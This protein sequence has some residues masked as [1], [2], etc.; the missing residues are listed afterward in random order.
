MRYRY[1]ATQDAL[2]AELRQYFAELMTAEVRAALRSESAESGDAARSVVRRMGAD[3]WLGIGWPVEYGGQ[4]PHGGSSSSSSSTRS[5]GPDAPFPFV[6]LNTVGPALMAHGSEE[7]KATY[8]PR[9]LRGEVTSPSATPRPRPAPT[10]P[11]CS[12]RR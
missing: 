5:S 3:G 4:R 1:T 9:I 12:T 8:L 7:Q 11:R 2:R 10:W 6:T